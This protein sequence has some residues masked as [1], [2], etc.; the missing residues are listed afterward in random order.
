[1]N[2]ENE[3]FVMQTTFIIGV[4]GPVDIDIAAYDA[5]KAIEESMNNGTYTEEI[6][7][8]EFLEFLSPLPLIEPPSSEKKSPN[9]LDNSDFQS[10]GNVTVGLA[11][12]A[13]VMGGFFILL[14]VMCKKHQLS[15]QDRHTHL[16]DTTPYIPPEDLTVT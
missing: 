13:S 3:S 12:G 16:E 9:S 6:S 7:D 11:V 4:E 14:M 5:Y 8:V 15:R 2:D 1:M 10:D